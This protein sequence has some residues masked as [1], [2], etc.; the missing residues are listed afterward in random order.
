MKNARIASVLLAFFTLLV[1]KEGI[2]AADLSAEV[3][4]LV[5][6]EMRRQKTPGLSL[7]VV[8]DGKP[9]LV[10][11]YGFA[12]LEH[13][14]L[15]KPATIFQSGSIG[16]Q[17]TAA[18][19]M[20]LVEDG[21]IGL[22]EKI[23]K[24]LGDVPESWR[25]IT[26]RHLL[27]HTS[28][29]TDYPPDFDLRRDYS[30]DEL[31]RMVKEVPLAFPPGER[32]EYSNLGY[33]VLGI[34]IGKVA[35]QFYGD[36]LSE[37]VF[38]PAGM[39]TAR[40]INEADIIPNRAAGY[41]VVKDEIKNQNWVA[42]SVNTTADGSLYVSILD[43]IRWDSALTRRALFKPSTYEAMWSPAVLSS[44][45]RTSYG[46]GWSIKSVNGKRLMEH[47]GEWQGFRSFVARYVDDGVTVIV[48]ANSSSANPQRI[49]H[50]VAQVI[51]PSL[52]PRSWS[53]VE[54]GIVADHRQL[55]ESV[56]N[57]KVAPGRFAPAVQKSLFGDRLLD[58]VKTL[59]PILNFDLIRFEKLAE[60]NVYSYEIQF[61]S[62]TIAI[63]MVQTADGKISRLEIH[64]E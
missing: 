11:V 20:L 6:A 3:D 29:M 26:I 48:L 59:G 24:Y 33:V 53:V 42:P 51:D 36:F 34:T 18:A 12:N 31:L 39:T 38:K 35:G 19:V 16:K 52:K 9:L 62:M 57:G 49:A 41:R 45:K 63:E 46:F 55:F 37:R 60:G 54:P 40:V 23:G 50:G 5:K 30:E 1:V 44:G 13:R 2:I 10:K 61:G 4:A 15:V 64:P 17:F 25:S 7:A 21:R 32:W 27:S 58:H 47:G 56:L 28:G 8:R 43:M 14:V 22:D